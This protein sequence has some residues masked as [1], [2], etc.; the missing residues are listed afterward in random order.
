VASGLG[1][2]AR[3][4]AFALAAACGGAESL[5]CEEP[6]GASP[7]LERV[8]LMVRNVEISAEVAEGSAR[9]SA[10]AGRRCDLDALLWV[11]DAVGPGAVTLC[12]VE[13][14]VDLAFVRQG[15]VVALQ[16]DLPPCSAPCDECPAYGRDGPEIDAVLWFPAGQVDV[17]EGDS[18]TGL[19]GVALPAA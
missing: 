5:P 6:A 17:A 18:V 14:A 4:V 19:D 13:V 1:S 8:S 16:L 15:E 3:A 2:T 7:E 11:P 12:E 10:W 9:E